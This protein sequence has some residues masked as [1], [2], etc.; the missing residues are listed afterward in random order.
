MNEWL[1]MNDKPKFLSM[2]GIHDKV[3]IY[4]FIITP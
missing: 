1:E 4:L 2:F 3:F